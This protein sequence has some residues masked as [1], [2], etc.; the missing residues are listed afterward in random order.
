MILFISG[1]WRRCTL[2]LFYSPISQPL[3]SLASYCL[4]DLGPVVTHSL[5]ALEFFLSVFLVFLHQSCQ[6]PVL[7]GVVRHLFSG[8]FTS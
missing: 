5:L 4:S 3:F 6:D 8:P 1:N 2:Q 7:S